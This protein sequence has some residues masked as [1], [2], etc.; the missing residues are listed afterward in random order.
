MRSFVYICDAVGWRVVVR[1]VKRVGCG[2]DGERKW[3]EGGDG[4]IAMARLMP[5]PF[6][7]R[8][9]TRGV[10]FHT[11]VVGSDTPIIY[12]VYILC[13]HCYYS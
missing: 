1:S 12:F 6:S 3:A 4:L 5:I 2:M 13:L 7:S 9:C 10:L 8:F 11:V